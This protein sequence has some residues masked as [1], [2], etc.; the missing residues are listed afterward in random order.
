MTNTQRA[1]LWDEINRY[2]VTCG[3]DPSKHVYGN[4][5][6]MAA[7]AGVERVVRDVEAEWSNALR[8]A[9]EVQEAHP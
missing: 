6:R 2:V 9:V 1:R 7:V 3:G 4:T 5:S 8:A